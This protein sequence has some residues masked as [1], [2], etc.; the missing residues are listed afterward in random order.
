M[1][2]TADTLNY[3]Q[4]F[5]R[6]F[7]PTG[8]AC[9]MKETAEPEIVQCLQVSR[10]SLTQLQKDICVA[11]FGG[12]AIVTVAPFD[13]GFRWIILLRAYTKHTRDY[14]LAERPEVQRRMKLILNLRL[15]DGFETFPMLLCQ[16]DVA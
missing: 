10:L 9:L 1:D 2:S 3:N 16:M 15:L 14:A 6:D 8:L 12:R 7:V 11:D 5:V 13:S 4:V